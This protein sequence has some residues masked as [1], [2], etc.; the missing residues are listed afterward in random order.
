MLKKITVTIICFFL[1]SSVV[2]ADVKIKEVSFEENLVKH[3][4]AYLMEKSGLES[5]QIELKLLTKTDKV[6]NA[7]A[8]KTLEIRPHIRKKIGGI[9]HIPIKITSVQN[10]IYKKNITFKVKLFGTVLVA[11]KS[12]AKHQKIRS[13]DFTIQ[14]QEI[15]YKFGKEKLYSNFDELNHYRSVRYLPKGGILSAENIEKIPL[16]TKN[17]LVIVFAAIKGIRAKFE[18]VAMSDAGYGETISIKNRKTKK[19]FIA[20]VLDDQHVEVIF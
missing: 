9:I 7:T 16:I 2:K 13:A 20:K 18:G 4:R 19:T 6:F 12:L 3:A 11:K 8:I 17:K 14:T 10:K 15:T 5:S 1:L